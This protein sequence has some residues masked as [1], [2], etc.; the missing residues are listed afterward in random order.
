MRC[1][2]YGISLQY[3]QHTY[4][5]MMLDSAFHYFMWSV[6]LQ[7]IF[8]IVYFFYCIDSCTTIFIILTLCLSFNICSIFQRDYLTFF[9]EVE[10]D[11]IGKVC[12]E[13]F[14]FHGISLNI[15]PIVCFHIMYYNKYTTYRVRLA[16]FS[17]IECLML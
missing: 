13:Y 1:S 5:F 4:P 6:S 15:A 9:S 12:L 17:I 8:V 14:F 11:V 2:N 10:I 16:N 3:M 7:L